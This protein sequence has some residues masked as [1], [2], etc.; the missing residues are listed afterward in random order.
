MDKTKTKYD[1][2]S[3]IYIYI[4]DD[5]YSFWSRNNILPHKQAVFEHICIFMFRAAVSICIEWETSGIV[6]ILGIY[7]HKW[8]ISPEDKILK[9]LKYGN[10]NIQLRTFPR[11]EVTM[12]KPLKGLEKIFYIGNCRNKSVSYLFSIKIA[13][14]KRPH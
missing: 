8:N 3:F 11:R 7:L 5:I 12:L 14:W 1:K 2:I 6:Y 13:S 10:Y 9:C 4:L